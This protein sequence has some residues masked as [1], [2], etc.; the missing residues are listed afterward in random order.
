MTRQSTYNTKQ[1]EVVL[2]YIIS[3]DGAH[4]TAAQIAAHFENT[5]IPIGRTT[6]YRHLDKLTEIGALRRYVTDGVSGAC[7]QFVNNHEGCQVH[8]HLKCEHCN[9]LQHLACDC[10]VDIQ[11]LIR[12]KHGFSIN[13]LKTVLYGECNNCNKKSEES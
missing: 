6:I 4:I 10:L 7:Y 5:D 2:N 13:G 3:L 9:E 8:L 1:R 12:E 11:S